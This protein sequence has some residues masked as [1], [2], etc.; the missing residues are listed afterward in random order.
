MNTLSSFQQDFG[1]GSSFISLFIIV[2]NFS[3]FRSHLIPRWHRYTPAVLRYIQLWDWSSQYIIDSRQPSSTQSRL[4]S[5]IWLVF[6][7]KTNKLPG[8]IRAPFSFLPRFF[9]HPL[10]SL[11][12]SPLTLICSI[13]CS[14]F[15][16]FTCP[17]HRQ[18]CPPR[19]PGSLLKFALPRPWPPWWGYCHCA[20]W[21]D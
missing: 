7:L 14:L 6:S 18:L 8:Y 13:V 1:C 20:V 16:L 11:S 15:L 19:S 12:Y 21:L 9:P 10:L 4:S 17:R 3:Q 2:H 5:A